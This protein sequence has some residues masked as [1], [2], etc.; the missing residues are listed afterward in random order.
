MLSALTKQ[1]ESWGCKVT[2]ISGKKQWQQI[3][4]TQLKA[5]FVI[6]D[7][8]LDDNDNG[9]DLVSSIFTQS[10]LQLPC[11]VCS[12]DPSEE[13]RQ[14]CADAGFS[15]MKKP[16]KALALKRLIKQLINQT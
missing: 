2:A 11:I 5:D 10:N 1:I 14:H 16:V 3:D 7:Y 12:A 6:A 8:H 9:V 13:L 15:F 4:S